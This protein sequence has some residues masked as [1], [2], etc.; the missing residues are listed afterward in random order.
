MTS[1]TGA[2]TVGATSAG[3]HAVAT[4]DASMTP[5]IWPHRSHRWSSR[6]VA[7]RIWLAVSAR[8]PL[9]VD[10]IEE[11]PGRPEV[12]GTEQAGGRVP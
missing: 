9:R 1:L 7:G 3:S 5:R 8:G 6:A 10:R 4:L 2:R 11:Q 12:E